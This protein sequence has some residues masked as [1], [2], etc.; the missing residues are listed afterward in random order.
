MRLKYI[1]FFI[2]LNF[3]ATAHAQFLPEPQF[4]IL[5][6]Y[7]RLKIFPEEGRLEAHDTLT[8]KSLAD[9]VAKIEPLTLQ[10]MKIK[11]VKVN[12]EKVKRK[13]L[14][15][16]LTIPLAKALSK[17]EEIVVDIFYETGN[18]YQ[19]VKV[20]SD[21]LGEIG[22]V[23]QI[24]LHSS[25]STH[26]FYYPDNDFSST[27]DIEITV[28]K[29]YT[30]VSAGA[31]LETK[32][33]NGFTTFHWKCNSGGGILP[34]AWAVAKYKKFEG[35]SKYGDKIEIYTLPEDEKYGDEKLKHAIEIVDFLTGI[36][37]KNP[38]EKVGVVEIDPKVGVYG[39][40]TKMLAFFSKK[41]YFAVPMTSD[42]LKT[43]RSN[44]IGTLVLV[45]EISH[46]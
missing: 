20:E 21:I 9:N 43:K 27:A 8:I 38:F 22:S 2:F 28:P 33:E 35:V 40:S 31:L 44:A 16:V 37:G 25:Y 18:Y 3:A 11:E 17:D 26:G 39:C 30:A 1:V 32:E 19:E 13:Y 24:N 12:G 15:P 45:D 42:L 6:H 10:E 36:Y 34:F 7:L 29:D 46:Q 23:A 5:H 41:K 4:K 14:S